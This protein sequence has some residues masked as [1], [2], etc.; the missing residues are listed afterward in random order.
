MREP[1]P[2]KAALRR[3]KDAHALAFERVARVENIPCVRHHEIEVESIVIR[4][5]HD[6]IGRGDLVG[7]GVDQSD[8][9]DHI[10][11]ENEG[12]NRPTAAP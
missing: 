4:Q 12:I 3:I 10:G 2:S 7:R 6:G 8:A 9:S 11:V 5:Q 1:P